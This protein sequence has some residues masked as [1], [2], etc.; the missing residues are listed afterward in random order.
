MTEPAKKPNR[1]PSKL[2]RW[3]F[4]LTALTLALVISGVALEVGLRILDPYG[5]S[6][7]RNLRA[8]NAKVLR[9]SDIPNLIF[10]QT[11]GVEVDIGVRV[12]IDRHGLRSD[13]DMPKSKPK[14]EKRLLVLGDSVAFGWGV[15][16]EETFCARIEKALGEPWRV[17][18]SG[19]VSYNTVQEEAFLRARGLALEPDAILL[20][21]C[22]ND[23]QRVNRQMVDG[24]GPRRSRP[25]ILK[26]RVSRLEWWMLTN[27]HDLATTDFLRYL[28]LNELQSRVRDL[29]RS[30]STEDLSALREVLRIAEPETSLNASLQALL[31]CQELARERGLPFAVA[32][33]S[34]PPELE[35]A[36]QKA[37]IPLIDTGFDVHS[38]DER[39]R[40]S[41]VDAHPNAAGHRLLAERILAGLKD[42]GL[43]EGQ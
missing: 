43:L 38:Q 19:V 29:R 37:G 1:S 12:R 18:D 13:R 24:A 3:F 22:Y 26:G 42:H 40:L 32:R 20:V 5:V 34:G 16:L 35:A 21:Y 8:Y 39:Y 11:P 27:R 17:V 10:E 23:T 2:R 28:T 25:G 7:F 6:Y 30:G 14:G 33:F 4:R 41:A 9:P 31:R 36:C 15:E